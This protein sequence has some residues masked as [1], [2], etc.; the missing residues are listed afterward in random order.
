MNNVFRLLAIIVIIAA[1]GFLMAACSDDGSDPT[2][3]TYTSYDASG[4]IYTLVVNKNPNRA[5]YIPQSG[6]MYVLTITSPTGD[7]IGTSS[8]TVKMFTPTDTTGVLTLEKNG[9]E[10]SVD[11]NSNAIVSINGKIPIDNGEPI[12]PPDI[13]IPVMSADYKY[14]INA[15]KKTITITKYIGA[16]GSVGIPSQLDGKTVTGIGK[17]AFY[18]CSSVNSVIIPYSVT[19]IGEMAFQFC[20]NLTDV[21]IGNSVKSIGEQ[22]FVG[23]ISLTSVIIPDSVTDIE[24]MTF[25]GC[26]NLTDVIIGNNVKSIGENAFGICSS[27]NNITIGNSVES[28]GKYAFHECYSLVNVIIPDSVKSIGECAFIHCSGLTGVTIPDSVTSIGDAAFISCINLTSVTIGNG[29]TGIGD[30]AFMFCTNLTNV[31]IGKRVSVIGEDA[32]YACELRSV[33]IPSS[34]ISIGKEA[35]QDNFRLT[36]VTFATGSNITNFGEAAFGDDGESLI[37]AYLAA[38]PKA[39][40]Y[41]RELG[42]SIWTKN[43]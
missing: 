13:L 25:Y 2:S 40:T 10:F 33:T 19:S 28:I 41:T 18:E 29:L 14:E 1:I 31:T 6:D 16:G 8:G 32:F 35:F 30:R 23:C 15:D 11:I 9:V 39:G 5:V 24:K 7:V 34:V 37:S 38:N 43:P 20:I 17:D 12:P 21:T 26:Y 27:L 22:A 4:N 3:V 42:G 36:S